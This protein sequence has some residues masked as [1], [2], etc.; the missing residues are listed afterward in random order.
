MGAD[1][2]FTV[3]LTPCWRRQSTTALPVQGAK[4]TVCCRCH[5]A[6][7]QTPP[8][9][10][11][12][13][14]LAGAEQQP[15]VSPLQCL[16]RAACTSPLTDRSCLIRES[17]S[18]SKG[19]QLSNKVPPPPTVASAPSEVPGT[20][21]R[22]HSKLHSAHL[23]WKRQLHGTPCSV[24]G[25]FC[26]I[27]HRSKH[28]TERVG[29]KEQQRRCTHSPRHATPREQPQTDR[30]KGAPC[31]AET[32]ARTPLRHCCCTLLSGVGSSPAGREQRSRTN[33][34]HNE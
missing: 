8:A 12:Q 1:R 16:W 32:H 5:W 26:W 2:G 30:P 27:Q 21:G 22:G 25:S 34:Q 15:Q 13:K 3:T 28:T 7:T 18:P 14:T 33:Q 11:E 17:T 20:G 19:Q 24:P 29:Q 4:A 10:G 6:G 31:R 23:S 9:P